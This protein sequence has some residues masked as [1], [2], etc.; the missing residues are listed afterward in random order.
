MRMRRY[1]FDLNDTRSV[2]GAG[3]ALLDNDS[4]ARKIAQDL[5]QGV[6]QTRPE[7]IGQGYEIIVRSEAGDEVLREAI[8]SDA[9]GN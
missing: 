1:H 7:L 3:G 4:Q 2:T 8:D 5:V 6:R 9:D